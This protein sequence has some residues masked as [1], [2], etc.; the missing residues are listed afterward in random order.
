MNHEIALGRHGRESVKFDLDVLLRTRLLIQANS[1][2]G[3]SWVGRRII[4]Q[5]FGKA[6]IFIYDPEGEF[7]TLR[8]Q[9]GFVL[10]G[11]GGETPT[12]I[13]SAATVME[14]FLELGVS[15][16]FDLYGLKPA[17]RHRY[18]KESL[19]A[20]MNA[21]KKFWAPRIVVVDEAHKFCPEGKAGKSEASEAM[22][23]LATAGRK[24]GLCAVWMTQRLA[25]LSKDASG[26]L[27]NRL[28]GPTF[29]DVDLV[30]AADLL[31]IEPRKMREFKKEMKLL[32]PGNFYALGRAISKE[33]IMVKIGPVQTSHPE[34]SGGKFKVTVPPPPDKIKKLLPKLKDLPKQAEDKARTVAEFQKEIRSLK[35]QLRMRPKDLQ[36]K[37]ITKTIEVSAIKPRDLSKLVSA[38]KSLVAAE[39][40]IQEVGAALLKAI[41][42]TQQQRPVV[43]RPV[44]QAPMRPRQT[45]IVRRSPVVPPPPVD[46]NGEFSK[47]EKKIG[48]VLA[49]YP[50]GCTIGKIAL[51]AG[52][53]V[54]GGFRN[55]LGK[56]RTYGY[57]AGPNTSVMTLTEDG[58]SWAAQHSVAIPEGMELVQ[59][60]LQH[61]S[62]SLCEKKITQAM[63]S[64]PDG[65]TIE[66]VA[67]ETGYQVSGGFRNSLGTLRTAG[68]LV[69]KNTE[70]MRLTED[71]LTASA[72]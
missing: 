45:P 2:G 14:K 8:E 49:N 40:K 67:E 25:K 10:V 37:V 17:M 4:E 61:P 68:V 22:T 54:S 62:F 60:W 66:E 19:T 27:L 16:I 57:L 55:S 31:S 44:T 46:G 47:A 15:A 69:G 42:G 56:L 3:K 32:E 33:R 70:T 9:F 65:M 11:E 51:L 35:A 21:P 28:V 34:I 13:S 12:H 20:L 23:D 26:E 58:H 59:Y 41:H 24:R 52:Y 50:E 71:L 53:R 5:A 72:H 48:G 64:R 38:V 36:T 39:N 7:V 43:S 18:I 30:R 6:P 1:G 29:E 63:L